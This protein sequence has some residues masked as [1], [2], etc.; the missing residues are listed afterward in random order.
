M[1]SSGELTSGSQSAALFSEH[2]SS[3]FNSPWR[4]ELIDLY[5]TPLTALMI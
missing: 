1:D 2:F 5:F 4:G 3:V